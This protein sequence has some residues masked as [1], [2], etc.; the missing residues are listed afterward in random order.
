VF[1]RIAFALLLGCLGCESN[2]LRTEDVSFAA[3]VA[4]TGGL[5]SGSFTADSLTYRETGEE[6]AGSA[7]LHLD[8]STRVFFEAAGGSYGSSSREQLKVGQKI[9]VWT[10]GVEIR[11]LVPQYRATQILIRR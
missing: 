8:E 3:R 2:P 10:T 9:L 4:E 5:A 6:Y 1:R 11:T 7:V